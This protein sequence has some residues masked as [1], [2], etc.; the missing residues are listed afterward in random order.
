MAPRSSEKPGEC[1]EGLPSIC[2]C[3]DRMTVGAAAELGRMGSHGPIH[4][5]LGFVEALEINVWYQSHWG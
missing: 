5:N 1:Q 2:S 4:W 3:V